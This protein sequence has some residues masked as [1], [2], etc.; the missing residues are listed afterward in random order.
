MLDV[1]M[2]L[3]LQGSSPASTEAANYAARVVEGLVH[4]LEAP[5]V[6]GTPYRE[7]ARPVIAWR[8]APLAEPGSRGARALLYRGSQR[9]SITLSRQAKGMGWR[10]NVAVTPF[11]PLSRTRR[12]LKDAQLALV[13]LLSLVAGAWAAI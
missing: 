1:T 2:Q 6:T 8:V 3:R 12:M 9:Y 4:D 11:G 10:L 5:P 7:A 13:L